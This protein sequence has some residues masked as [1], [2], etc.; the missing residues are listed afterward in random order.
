M[1]QTLRN[2]MFFV[3]VL[4]PLA[5]SAVPAA[6]VRRVM[7][8]EGGMSVEVTLRG[9]EHLSLWQTDDGVFMRPNAQGVLHRL[10]VFELE[11]LRADVRTASNEGNARRVRRRVG[12]F[13]PLTGKKRG[14]IILV[15]FQDNEFTVPQPQQTFNDFFNKAGYTDYGMTGSVHDYFLAQSYGL[16]ELDFDVVGPY[17]LQYKMSYYGAPNGNSVDSN[18]AQMIREAC[19]MAD[20]SVNFADYDWDGDGEVDQVFVIYAGY[21]ENYGAPENTVWPHESQLGDG[22]TLDGTRVNT[23]ACSCEL[24]GTTG[25]MVDG[26]GTACHEFSHCLGFPDLYDVTYG[27]SYGMSFWDLMDSGSYNNNGCTPAGYSAYERWMAGWLK[28][29]ELTHQEEITDM[30]PLTSAPEA[31]ILYNEGNRDEYYLLENRQKEGFDA[32][33][34]GHGLLVVHVDYDEKVWRGNAVNVNKNRNRLTIIA[35]DGDYQLTTASLAADPFPGRL[36]VTALTDDTE[37]ASTL[38]NANT[39]RQLLMHKSVE[40][41]TESPEGLI[42]FLALR[43]LLTVPSLKLDARTDEGFAV[44]WTASD[45]AEGYDLLLTEYPAKGDAS[46]SRILEED[47]SGAYSEKAGLVDVSSKLNTLLSTQGFSGTALYTSPQRLRIGTSTKQ[48][49]LCSPVQRALDTGQL[50][51]VLT[52]SAAS[53]DRE[54]TGM[55]DIV[56]NNKET[57]HLKFSLAGTATIVLHP[58][59][60]LDEIFRVDVSPSSLAYISYMALYDGLFTAEELG[61]GETRSAQRAPMRVSS[62]QLSVTG[63]SY[64]FTGL[65]TTSSYTLSIRAKDNERA[66]RWSDDFFI[67]AFTTPDAIQ[68]V[69][70]ENNATVRGIYDLQGRRQNRLQKGL[71]IIDGRKVLVK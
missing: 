52:L 37:P 39:D 8:A 69:V 36:G 32:A 21:G 71:N 66:S 25:S 35:A 11:N 7:Q 1:K 14:L 12:S 48:G 17:K 57:E 27:D 38:Y 51:V 64:T 26:I 62:S 65:S 58:E 29:R 67:E 19:R 53:A 28:P 70:P 20:G 33:L 61:I 34:Y 44:S 9:D 23:Y 59:T 30:A 3:A 55:V 18:P 60:V 13:Q 31:Y 54:L 40:R 6:P 4:L 24:K 43:P 50:T 42:S 10:S 22:L 45:G 68:S 16:F 5:A 46:S 56:T 41:I 49:T 15:S 63:T 47:F 2:F